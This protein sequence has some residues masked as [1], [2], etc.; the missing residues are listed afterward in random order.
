MNVQISALYRPYKRN[1]WTAPGFGA[2]AGEDGNTPAQVVI[3]Q[4][5]L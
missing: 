3:V 5:L 4:P 1:V 2:A